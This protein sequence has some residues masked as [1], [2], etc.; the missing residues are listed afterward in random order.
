MR[1]AVLTVMPAT[2]LG[3]AGIGDPYPQTKGPI[4]V[5][6]ADEGKIRTAYR[7]RGNGPARSG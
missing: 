7:N 4:G 3:V 5:D 2:E 6:Q 1:T